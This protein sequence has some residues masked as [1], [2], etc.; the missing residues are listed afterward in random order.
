MPD[1]MP[2]G[3][4]HG[5]NG[6]MATSSGFLQIALAVANTTQR[7]EKCQ[8]QLRLFCRRLC[9]GENIILP[10]P[11]A[12]NSHTNRGYPWPRRWWRRGIVKSSL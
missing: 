7:Y 1:Q 10:G 5:N 2:G 6:L 12:F 3:G 8:L 11:A 9:A 4:S